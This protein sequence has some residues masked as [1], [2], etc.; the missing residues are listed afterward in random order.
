MVGFNDILV[1]SPSVWPTLA[2]FRF[3][4]G[5]GG[6]SFA[7]RTDVRT[8]PNYRKASLLIK[9]YFQVQVTTP[10]SYLDTQIKRNQ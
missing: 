1:K 3:C 5:G 9:F 10:L 7:E 8:D 2:D 4:W 6:I